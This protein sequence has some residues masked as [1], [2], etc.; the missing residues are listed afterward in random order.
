MANMGV[1]MN[2]DAPAHSRWAKTHQTETSQYRVGD[3]P[4]KKLTGRYVSPLS[5]VEEV[6][7][8]VRIN[9]SREI[10]YRVNGRS[11]G[12]SIIGAKRKGK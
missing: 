7:K 5:A 3:F 9:Y 1:E 6:S 4:P 2:V 8:R 11:F 12:A 10:Q